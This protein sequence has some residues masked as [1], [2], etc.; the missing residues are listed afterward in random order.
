M[1]QHIVSYS[2]GKDSAA[3]ANRRGRPFDDE[4]LS[5]SSQYRL[6]E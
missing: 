2:T 6:C 3:L 1:T 5:C 4:G